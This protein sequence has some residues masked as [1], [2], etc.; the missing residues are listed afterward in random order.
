MEKLMEERRS[1]RVLSNDDNID[2]KEIK[3]KIEFAFNYCPTAYDMQETRAIVLFDSYHEKL[4]DIVFDTLKPKVNPDKLYLTKDKINGFKEGNGTILYFIDTEI[5]SENKKQNESVSNLFDEWQ[6]HNQG[7][8]QYA[9]WCLL[10]SMDL[11]ASLQH[12][13]PIIDE[14]VKKEFNIPA[15]WR[16]VAQMPFGIINEKPGDKVFK[17]IKKKVVYKED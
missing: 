7:I 16:L 6:H 8:V 11:G 13:N 4:W 15:S 5:V 12:Y 3:E 9:I 1:I 10:R 17:D 2:R 14:D